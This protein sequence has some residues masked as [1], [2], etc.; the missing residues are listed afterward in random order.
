MEYNKCE[1]Q[2]IASMKY[3]KMPKKDKIVDKGY[4]IYSGYKI[5]G[6]YEEYMYDDEMIIVV[7]RGVGGTGDVKL[8]PPKSYITNLSIILDTNENLVDKKYLQL[9]LHSM[10]LKYLDSGSAQS[11]ITINDLKRLKICLPNIKHQ[12]KLSSFIKLINR[13]IEINQNIIANLE[14][15]SKTLFKRWF[16]DF[17]FPDE[18]GNPYKS[19][20]GE[21]VDSELGKIPKGWECVYL[22]DIVHHKKDTFNP[23][24][25]NES[26]VKHFS[27]PAFDS[28]QYPTIDNVTDI[29]SNKWIIDENCILF[30]KMNPTTRRIWV[31]SYNE[32]FLNVASSEFVVLKSDNSYRNAFIYNICISDKFNEYL[33]SNTTGST[34]S[35]QRVK[36]DIAVQYRFAYNEEVSYLL[37]EKIEPYIE[38]IKIIREQNQNL[39]QIR[40]TLLPKLMSGEIEIPDDIEVN[41]DELS[42]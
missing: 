27:L 12:K 17:E 25:S 20:G 39:T 32:N 31:T 22:K 30:S 34:N 21:M 5:T 35:R 19:S 36:P 7:A 11:Q 42:I 9:L 33:V 10:K 4:P 26:E 16:V 2:E 37:S 40:D 1:L 8:S 18:N 24:K 38:K 13:K 14:E 29:K 3:G 15:L 6:F 23:K 41:E 28:G